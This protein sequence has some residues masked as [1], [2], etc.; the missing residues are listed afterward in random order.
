MRRLAGLVGFLLSVWVGGV[1]LVNYHDGGGRSA[2]S[3]AVAAGWFALVCWV[4]VMRG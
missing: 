1:W 3:I 2:L 4:R